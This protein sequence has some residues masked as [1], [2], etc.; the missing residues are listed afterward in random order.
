M[1]VN[2]KHR[3]NFLVL[4]PR[5][6]SDF[7]SDLRLNISFLKS[8]ILQK[9]AKAQKCGSIQKMEMS[10]DFSLFVCGKLLRSTF[11]YLESLTQ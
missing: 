4:Q 7:Q 6:F 2:V 10:K 8:F 9:K 3:L 1:A 11:S 5:K